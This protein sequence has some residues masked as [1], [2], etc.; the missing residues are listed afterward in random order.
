MR[1]GLKRQ[2]TLAICAAL[3]LFLCVPVLAIELQAS[4]GS[5][6]VVAGETV[7]VNI[8]VKGEKLAA[9]EG[10]FTYDPAL[11]SYTESN[12][13]A[14]D[15]FIN[16]ATAEKGGS[17]SLSAHARFTAIAAGE[18]KISFTIEK[19]LDY[20]GKSS[21]GASAEV[22]ISVQAAPVEETPKIDY[23]KEG[24]S[25]QNV[26]G[27]TENLYIW[28]S[29]DNVTIPSKYSETEI[30]Y[31]GEKVKGVSVTDSDAPTLL[32]LS[33]AAG[34]NAAYYVYDAAQDML[35]PYQTIS[36]VSKSYI[37]LK[38]DSG[39]QI[40]EGFSEDSLTVDEKQ[41]TVWKTQDA[42][43]D[44][45]LVYGRN[46][47]GEVGFFYYNPQDASLQRYAVLPARPVQPQLTPS[48]APVPTEAVETEAPV[49][50][51]PAEK[52]G[53]ITMPEL[54][55]YAL[56]G[57]VILLIVILIIVLACHAAEKKRRRERAEKRRA[58]RERAAKEQESMRG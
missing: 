39:V 42:A 31:H 43:G 21:D 8:T 28:K 50:Q 7:D 47:D 45:Y 29:I 54:Y 30:D 53:T 37:L 15:G 35:Y 17:S 36:S 55:V 33:N 38:P 34:E 26:Q 20:E 40:P 1:K 10:V 49:E 57:A 41:I 32:Y 9:V 23:S 16:M 12:G 2:F 22:T 52:E 18:A 13:G 51:A 46:P 19:V 56:C 3:V 27:A 6:S 58:E 4:A 44:V 48:P 5:T 25:A 14:G 24:V 11:I